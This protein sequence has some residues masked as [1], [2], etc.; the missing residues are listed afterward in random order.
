MLLR[1]AEPEDAIAVARVHVRSWQAAYRTLLPDDYLDQ[2]RPED[3]AEKYDFATLDPLK[4]QTIVAV[5]EGLIRGFATTAPSREADLPDHGELYA[6]YVDP[7]QWGRGMGVAL[8]SAARARLY[9]LGFQN[10]V[11]W[12]MTGNVRAERFYQIDG[13]VPDGLRR[14]ASMWDVT[15]D[16]ARY[17]RGLEMPS[18]VSGIQP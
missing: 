16:E 11:L 1:P 7:G 13:W 18:S 4:P 6:L 3:R 9:E 5:E 15:V 12:V 8:V 17:Q 14:T 10:A 2:L